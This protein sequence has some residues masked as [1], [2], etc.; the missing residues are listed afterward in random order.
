[1]YIN[2][3]NGYGCKIPTWR[4]QRAIVMPVTK[5]TT[6]AKKEVLQDTWKSEPPQTVRFAELS[7]IPPGQRKRPLVENIP[8]PGLPP[9]PVQSTN[10]S[11]K[12]SEICIRMKIRVFFF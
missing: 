4:Q 7:I 8:F 6:Q 2:K 9:F 3:I 1:M 5:Q 11:I 12:V 10:C